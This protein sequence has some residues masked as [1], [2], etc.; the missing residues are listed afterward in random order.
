[1]LE[2]PTEPTIVEAIIELCLT[3]ATIVIVFVLISWIM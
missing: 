2:D 1:M 3:A